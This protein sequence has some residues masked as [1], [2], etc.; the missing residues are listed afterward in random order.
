MLTFIG[1]NGTFF[2]MHMLGIA[3][4]PRRLADPYNYPYLEHLLPINQF[5]TCC[6][7]LMGFA[8][9]LLLGNFVYSI[10]KGPKVRPESVERQRARM[11]G[12]LAAGTRQLRH[13]CR[14]S[15]ADRTNMRRRWSEED[16]LPQ[17]RVPA[18]TKT[19]APIRMPTHHRTEMTSDSRSPRSGCIASPC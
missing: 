9:F 16:F 2:P 12:S 3:G 18:A 7:I 5:M 11:D 4:M 19:V 14:S 13:S 6:A 15:T 17:T 10:F 1:F 8:Q